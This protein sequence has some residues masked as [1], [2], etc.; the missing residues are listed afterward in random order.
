[1]RI[2]FLAARSGL[3]RASRRAA[4]APPQAKG[5]GMNDRDR[6]EHLRGLLDRLERMPA[7]ADRNWMLA[8]IRARAVDVETGVTPSAVRALPHDEAAAAQSAPVA[9]KAPRARPKPP[10]VRT[11]PRR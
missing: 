3:L 4:D 6:L 2:E 11:S 5:H 10:R 8:E 1:M 9:A 7:S